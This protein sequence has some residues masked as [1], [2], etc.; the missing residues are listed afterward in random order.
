VTRELSKGRRDARRILAHCGLF[1]VAAAVTLAGAPARAGTFDGQGL[2]RYDPSTIARLDFSAAPER[3]LPEGIE[4]KCLLAGFSAVSDDSALEGDGYLK[5]RVPQ[6]CAERFL[7][8]LPRVPASYRATVW[9][10]HGSLDAQ[11]TILYPEDSGLEITIARMFPTGRVT[12]DGW[13]ELASN[14]FPVDGALTTATYL[15]VYDFAGRDGVDLDGLEIVP[16]GEYLPQKTC[17]GLA[18]PACG[19]EETCIYQ[20]CRLGR[21]YVPPLPDP[22]LKDE[23]V[24]VLQGRLRIFFGGKKTRAED[25]PKALAAMEAMRSAETAWQ[26]W[27]AWAKGIRLLHDWHTHAGAPINVAPRGRLNACFFEGDADVS[28]AVWP[29]D[30][31]FA[32]VL[33]SHAGPGAAGLQAGD[34]L[35]AVDGVH[36]LEWAASLVDVNLSSYF[37][38]S[39]SDVFAEFAESL[40]G[41]TWQGGALILKYARTLT[42]L[43]CDAVTETC[44]DVPETL[45]VADL[46]VAAGG[47]D[48]ACDNR[49]F[50][51]LEPGQNPSPSNHYVFGDFFRG[52]VANTTPEEAI[53]GMIWDT[54]YGGGDPGGWVNGHI[55]EAITDWK[56]NARGVIL[57]HRAGNGGTLDAAENLTKLVRPLEPLAVIRMPIEIGGDDGPADQAEGLALFNKWKSSDLAFRVGSAD[58]DPTLPVALIL[59]RDGSASDYMPFGMKGAPKV[60][61]FGPHATAGAFSTFINFDYWGGISFQIASG[62]TI[63]HDG[64]PLLGHGVEPDVVLLPRQSDLLAGKDTLHEAALA[65]VRQ[66]LAP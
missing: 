66:E 10:R 54:L 26:F 21:G 50:Y 17:A 43:R 24:D 64:T 44:S 38:A 8:T 28:H 2:Y 45:V 53:Y 57:D 12:S 4:D 11:M 33:V 41:P 29:K 52:R 47:E 65:W 49:P 56:A 39:D 20:R 23:V 32:D 25:L 48:V 36:P 7:V 13:V 58:H 5:L 15:R 62:D 22:S 6:G 9:M 61:L 3:Y 42:V 46:P 34:R 59:H 37:I 30:P 18:D 51:N 16:A 55:A 14:E 60:R 40:G 63:A 31:R 27:S 1:G 19:A 35:I